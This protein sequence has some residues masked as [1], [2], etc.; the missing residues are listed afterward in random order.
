MIIISVNDRSSYLGPYGIKHFK[1]CHHSLFIVEMIPKSINIKGSG[2]NKSKPTCTLTLQLFTPYDIKW[3]RSKQ[4][5]S[6]T[7][8]LLRAIWCPRRHSQTVW[9]TISVTLPIPIAQEISQT[10][11]SWQGITCYCWSES[12]LLPWSR[13]PT[14][15]RLQLKYN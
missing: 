14:A 11:F 1:A 5:V 3:R 2:L 4:T 8:R 15:K 10:C 6:N 12:T 7:H 9:F 13:P